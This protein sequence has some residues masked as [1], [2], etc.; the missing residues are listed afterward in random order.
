MLGVADG[1]VPLARVDGDGGDVREQGAGALRLD[2]RL[3]TERRGQVVLVEHRSVSGA[4]R[5]R[6]A[7]AGQPVDVR[8]EGVGRQALADPVVQVAHG[9][10]ARG[11]EAVGPGDLGARVEAR[12]GG[13]GEERLIELDP[14]GGVGGADGHGRLRGWTASGQMVPM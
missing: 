9:N 14:E 2:E 4:G 8:V 6:E 1:E 3:L 10:D 12:G 7:G 13:V 5:G 11:V